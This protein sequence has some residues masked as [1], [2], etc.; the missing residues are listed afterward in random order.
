[1]TGKNGVPEHIVQLLFGE[2]KNSDKENKEAVQANTAAIM[3]LIKIVGNNPADIMEE[4]KD[5]KKELKKV[6]DSYTKLK[7][8]LGI[9]IAIIGIMM[10]AVRVVEW[11]LKFK[12]VT[13]GG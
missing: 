6:N 10:T 1:M 7:W 13:G 3:E 4:L 12:E 11:Y 5:I 2:L 8:I 9:T